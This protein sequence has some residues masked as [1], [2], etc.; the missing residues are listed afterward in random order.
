L[1]S[2]C[3]PPGLTTQAL[4]GQN[5]DDAC[6]GS[7]DFP[8]PCAPVQTVGG[9][10]NRQYRIDTYVEY[11]NNDASLSIRTPASGLTLKRV[12]VLARDAGT[13]QILARGSSAFQQPS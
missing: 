8:D 13:G 10:D 12:V 7:V 1:A 5:G 11:V 9:P 3:S 4:A 2:G 6:S